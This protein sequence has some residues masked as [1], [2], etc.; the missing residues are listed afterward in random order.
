MNVHRLDRHPIPMDIR[1]VGHRLKHM[2]MT[3]IANTELMLDTM[4]PT[5]ECH[6]GLRRGLEP[7]AQPESWRI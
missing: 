3:G 1:Q 5:P 6:E 7:S 2:H 4:P